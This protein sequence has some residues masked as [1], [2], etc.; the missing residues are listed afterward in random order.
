MDSGKMKKR[1]VSVS[2]LLAALMSTVSC[3]ITWKAK[4]QQH[5]RMSVERDV[6]KCQTPFKWM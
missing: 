2:V 6:S 3:F 4:Q 5:M 1:L